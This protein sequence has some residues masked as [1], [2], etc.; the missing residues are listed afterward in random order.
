MTDEKQNN[1]KNAPFCAV[2]KSFYLTEF[3]ENI[4]K[5]R[6]NY[7]KVRNIERSVILKIRKVKKQIYKSGNQIKT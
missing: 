4:Q 1:L 7:K 2:L 6:N 3:K 5:Q